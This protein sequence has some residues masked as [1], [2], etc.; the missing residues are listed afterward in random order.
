MQTLLIGQRLHVADR[1]GTVGDRNGG[2]DQHPTWVV[3]GAAVPQP[4]GGLA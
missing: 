4:I 3:P 2:V 1:H